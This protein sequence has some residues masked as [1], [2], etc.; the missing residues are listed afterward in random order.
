LTS[1]QI[2][3]D[4]ARG[5]SY[6]ARSRLKTV[7]YPPASPNPATTI[8]YTYDADN[9]PATVTDNRLVAQGASSGTTT[10]SYDAVSNLS[11]YNYPN[12][13]QTTSTFDSLNRLK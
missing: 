10:Y 8:Q 13:V 12:T 4:L 2:A 1:P 6:D 5:Y 9:R 11:G 7:N 3:I